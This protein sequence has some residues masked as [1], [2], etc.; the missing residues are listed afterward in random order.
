MIFNKLEI[1]VMQVGELEEASRLAYKYSLP[2]V[3]IHSGLIAEGYSARSRVKGRY[4]ILIPVGWNK[5]SA[6]G[7]QKLYGLDIDS[8]EADGFEILLTPNKSTS[9]TKK[10]VSEIVNFLRMKVSKTAEIRFVLGSNVGEPDPS[11]D[12]NL[13]DG[14]VGVPSPNYIR[15]DYKN[16]LQIGKANSDIHNEFISNVR[17]KTSLPIKISGNI[18]DIKS[19]VA[20]KGASR[21]AVSLLQMKAIVK[22]FNNQRPEILEDLLN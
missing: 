10:E 12:I 22:E 15:N 1:D 20:C 2:S 18:N 14:I 9:E 8:L 11:I 13:L 16:K 5:N 21:F 6:F 4:K 19:V 7:I 17:Q 3:V